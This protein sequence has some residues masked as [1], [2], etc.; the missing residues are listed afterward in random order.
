MMPDSVAR[1]K[2]N[3]YAALAGMTAAVMLIGAF[4]WGAAMAQ[5]S[6]VSAS[7][8]VTLAEQVKQACATG[9]LVID[10]RN[11]CSKAES[12]AA[13][14]A[15]LVPGPPGPKGADGKDGETGPQGPPGPAGKNGAD[16]DDG[17]PGP[18]GA[19]GATGPAGADGLNGADG[20]PGVAGPA[21]APGADST[22]P[23]PAGPPGPAGADGAPG[24]AGP[25][26]PAGATGPAPS[27]FTFTDRTGATYTCTPNPPGSTTYTCESDGKVLP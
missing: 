14:P 2:R 21:G 13:A 18:A 4:L 9:Q 16:G 11:L 6:E 26:G 25:A 15:E 10:E 7:N 5:R 19:D 12:V 8:A 3:L 22:V 27:S 24:P 20:A 1:R 17:A 23:G